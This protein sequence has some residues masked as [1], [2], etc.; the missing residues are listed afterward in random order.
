MS[1]RNAS[2]IVGFF[3]LTL[4]A[5]ITSGGASADNIQV[6]KAWSRP[7]PPGTEVGVA[8]FVI[9]NC[10]ESDRLVGASSPV[11]TRAELHLSQMEGGVMKMRPLDAV[12]VKSWEPT[13]FEPS[14]RHVMLTGLKQPLR[15][16]DT[17][18]LVLTFAN[19]GPVKVQVHVR[20]VG[21]GEG[22]HGTGHSKQRRERP[23]ERSATRA[24]PYRPRGFCLGPS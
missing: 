2:R 9:N 18:L 22:N 19:A 7:T 21:A 17:F 12:E 15:E 23:D 8:Y 1:E 3:V 11:A 10:G 13:S 14:G 4:G 6:T 24:S 5:L 16:G 20:G